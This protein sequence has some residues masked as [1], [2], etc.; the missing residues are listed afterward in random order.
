MTASDAKIFDVGI[1]D[2]RLERDMDIFARVGQFRP[3]D[4]FFEFEL[5]DG[6][7]VVDV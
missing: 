3:F 4:L 2:A 7:I 6:T 5:R 1:G